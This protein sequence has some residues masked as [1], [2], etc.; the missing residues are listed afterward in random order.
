MSSLGFYEFVNNL[1]LGGATD[2]SSP[3]PVFMPPANPP[4]HQLQLRF[5]CVPRVNKVCQ[6]KTTSFFLF[7]CFFNLT[8]T[9]PRCCYKMLSKTAKSMA[10]RESVLGM[11]CEH[12]GTIAESHFNVGCVLVNS[13]FR[14]ERGKVVEKVPVSAESSS[15][16]PHGF[17]QHG[18]AERT[19]RFGIGLSQREARLISCQR[20]QDEIKLLS[21]YQNPGGR[22]FNY[23]FKN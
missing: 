1:V 6:N 2:K 20:L 19:G 12:H 15:K 9:A 22:S 11:C 16:F 5:G 18:L 23:D 14:K 13:C 8:K 3:T 10:Q 7:V 21:R 4:T 17:L